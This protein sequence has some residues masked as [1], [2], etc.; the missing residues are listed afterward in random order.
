MKNI[1]TH[2]PDT[3]TASAKFFAGEQKRG[4]LAGAAACNGEHSNTPTQ[5]P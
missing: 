2:T 1:T 5:N 4:T 3:G